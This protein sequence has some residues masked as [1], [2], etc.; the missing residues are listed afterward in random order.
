MCEVKN[1]FSK[2]KKRWCLLT[3]LN[4]IAQQSPAQDQNKQ[5]LH[6]TS[7]LKENLSIFIFAFSLAPVKPRE[8]W[9]LIYYPRFGCVVFFFVCAHANP[10]GINVTLNSPSSSSPSTFI[11]VVLEK[12]IN[13]WK[14]VHIN[15]NFSAFLLKSM[16]HDWLRGKAHESEWVKWNCQSKKSWYFLS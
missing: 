12:S 7:P 14:C 3:L 2:E 8:S 15:G 10:T 13:P 5:N 11:F 1:W 4:V 16:R 6:P 9:K